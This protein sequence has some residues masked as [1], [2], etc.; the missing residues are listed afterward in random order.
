MGIAIIP[1]E[2]L[3]RIGFKSTAGCDDNDGKAKQ[4]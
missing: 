2:L 4:P 1:D 3:H